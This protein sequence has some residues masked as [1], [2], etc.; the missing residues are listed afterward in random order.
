M[1]MLPLQPWHTYSHTS[2][3]ISITTTVATG[4]STPLCTQASSEGGRSLA[5]MFFTQ[6]CVSTNCLLVMPLL[7]LSLLYLIHTIRGLHCFHLGNTAI[8]DLILSHNLRNSI[9]MHVQHMRLYST[10]ALPQVLISAATGVTTAAVAA[11]SAAAALVF[12]E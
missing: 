10:I 11:A 4:T 12:V 7:P 2:N 6:F 3:S 5:L 1:M 8:P 9:N